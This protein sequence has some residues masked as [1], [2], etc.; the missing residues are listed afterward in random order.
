[1]NNN[2]SYNDFKNTEFYSTFI[3]N[4]LGRG[5]LKVIVSTASEAVPIVD[6]EVV[7]YQDIENYR[8][9]F[10]RGRTDSSGII[11]NIELPS[12]NSVTFGSLEVPEY[13]IYKLDIKANGYVDIYD[14]TVGVFSNIKVI[15]NVNLEPVVKIEK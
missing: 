13:A 14:Y 4:N 12:P 7:V 2:I 10:Y 5:Y 1:M 3:K 15:Q 11:D 6:A 8:V 9:I